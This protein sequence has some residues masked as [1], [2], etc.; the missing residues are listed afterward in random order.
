MSYSRNPRVVHRTVLV[1]IPKFSK[2]ESMRALLDARRDVVRSPR[3]PEDTE[4]VALHAVLDLDECLQTID[5]T[6]G[7]RAVLASAVADSSLT[8]P[9]C[10]FVVDLCRC[11][12]VRWRVDK[13]ETVATMRWASKSVCEQRLPSPRGRGCRS[14]EPFCTNRGAAFR[15]VL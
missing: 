4:I 5:A 11:N 12:E 3:L 13:G 7:P 6:A 8:T 2:L 15:R 14:G 9:D 1:F 10:N